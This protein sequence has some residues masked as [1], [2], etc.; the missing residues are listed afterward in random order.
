MNKQEIL[1]LIEEEDV[2]FIRLQFADVFGNLKNIAVTPERFE[3]VL[4]N[5]Y[6]FDGAGFFGGRYDF[7]EDLYLC[8]DLDTFVILPWRPQQSRVGKFICDIC[9]SDGTPFE[10]SSRYILEKIVKK[11]KDA[12]YTFVVNP[13]C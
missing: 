13:E 8:P 3:R 1:S 11:A 2:E 5:R 4:D 9:Y 7:D 10:M 12:G 6:P